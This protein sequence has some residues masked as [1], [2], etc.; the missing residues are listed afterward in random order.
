MDIK[1]IKLWDKPW[2]CAGVVAPGTKVD[3]QFE[4]LGTVPISEGVKPIKIGEHEIS[5]LNGVRGTC[6]CTNLQRKG[7]IVKGSLQIDKDYSNLPQRYVDVKKSIEVYYEDGS[8]GVL[9]LSAVADKTL[10]IA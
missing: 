8:S 9:Y 7:N 3:F 1:E 5:V 4:Y 6:G 2:F 10:E